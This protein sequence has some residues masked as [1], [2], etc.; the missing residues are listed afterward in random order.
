MPQ[1]EYF[2]FETFFTDKIKARG[3]SLERVSEQTGITLQ[4][5]ESLSRGRYED[6]PPAPYFRGYLVKLGT[7]LDFDHE[8]WWQR[9][10]AMGIVKKSGPMD[11]LPQN[12]FAK[13]S[14]TKYAAL[15]LGGLL[16]VGYLGFSLSRIL[17][18]PEL[19]I[20]YPRE[21]LITVKEERVLIYGEL[22]NGES[23]T[24]N[25]E[26]VIVDEDGAWEKEVF[27]E[28]G[29]NTLEITAKK[30]LGKEVSERRQL[31][32]EVPPEANTAPPA[33]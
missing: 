20:E 28:P 3:L 16:L 9:F 18:R 14:K 6:M 22:K 5:L 30:F 26:S 15:A 2:D 19:S 31:L 4:H 13:R 8:L 10:L 23:L 7:L 12:R 24:V 21:N 25:G 17:G 1:E 32:Y 33:E 11:Q 29:L 27:L